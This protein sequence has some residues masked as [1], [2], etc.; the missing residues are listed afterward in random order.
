MNRQG[1][2]SLTEQALPSGRNWHLY[3]ATRALEGSAHVARQ[4]AATL[5]V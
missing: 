5:L 3:V 1:Q 4:R 2:A